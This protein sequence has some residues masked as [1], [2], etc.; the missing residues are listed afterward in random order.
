MTLGIFFA[1]DLRKKNNVPVLSRVVGCLKCKMIVAQVSDS[2]SVLVPSYC[3]PNL[4]P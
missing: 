2:A 1:E 4:I 3:S